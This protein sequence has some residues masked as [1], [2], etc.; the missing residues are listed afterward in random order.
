MAKFRSRLV[1]DA[2]PNSDGTWTVTNPTA[3]ILD[4]TTKELY[5]KYQPIS[6]VL[7]WD[8]DDPPGIGRMYD[9]GGDEIKER[10]HYAD[11]DSGTVLY[12]DKNHQTLIKTFRA[13][14]VFVPE[15]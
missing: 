7:D 4:M 11:M 14:L 2:K 13:P 9:A 15:R 1:I 6:T 12:Y 5:E 10:V 3:D 8:G